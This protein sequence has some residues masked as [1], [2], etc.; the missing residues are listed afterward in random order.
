M[1]TTRLHFHRWYAFI[2]FSL[3]NLKKKKKKKKGEIFLK[4]F[5]SDSGQLSIHVTNRTQQPSERWKG[6]Y[7]RKKNVIS[8]LH[9]PGHTLTCMK[10]GGTRAEKKKRRLARAWTSSLRV[11][12]SET[13]SEDVWKGG[14]KRNEI[15]YR[16]RVR[17][18]CTHNR[19]RAKLL[20]SV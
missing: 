20:S 12:T 18:P 2:I 8:D 10:L 19:I 15:G 5:N 6:A 1:E 7:G 3:L 4:S 11:L 16:A 17:P 14:K 9:I 13:L